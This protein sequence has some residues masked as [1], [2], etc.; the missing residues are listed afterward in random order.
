MNGE[1]YDLIYSHRDYAAEATKLSE[2]IEQ[3]CT[4]GG[5][6]I[7]DAACGTGSNMKYLGDLGFSV[8]GFDISPEQIVAARKKLPG[9]PIVQADLLDFEMYQQYDVVLCLFNSIGYLKTKGNLVQVVANMARHTKPGGIII[10]EPWLKP[11]DFIIRSVSFDTAHVGVDLSVVRMAIS[12]LDNNITT[13]KLHHMVR[14]GREIKHFV[15]THELATYTDEDFNDAFRKAGLEPN[16][17][18]TGLRNRELRIGK[19]KP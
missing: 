7:L 14:T 19:K 3:H 17:D 2:L 13:L 12:D 6:R 9:A 5:N 15:E 8:D 11:E 10:I 4:S 1:V 18:P 16:A